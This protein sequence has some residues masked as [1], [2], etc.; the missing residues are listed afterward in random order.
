MAD[1][2][3]ASSPI[4]RSSPF[5][6]PV[7]LAAIALLV[8]APAAVRADDIVVS[9]DIPLEI[10]IAILLIVL[11]PATVAL[12]AVEAIVLNYFLGLGYWRCLM[13]AFLANAVS[14]ALGFAW[15]AVLGE[16][17][18]K[19]SLQTGQVDRIAALFLRSFIITFVEEG[20][21][22]SLLVGT[23]VNRKTTLAAVFL[24][25]VVSYVLLA[26]L[27]GGLHAASTPHTPVYR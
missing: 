20:L 18:W 16:E 12:A 26:V 11:T 9:F 10:E 23:A 1:H 8:L 3:A 22:I 2:R 21:V 4:G 24:A 5:P 7:V 17:G 14:I 25:N 27:L 19:M 13:Y 6:I 15:R